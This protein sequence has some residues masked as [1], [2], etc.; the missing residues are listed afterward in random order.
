M[1]RDPP[2]VGLSEVEARLPITAASVGQWVH[3]PAPQS[4]SSRV[5]PQAF[6]E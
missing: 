5:F 1:Q 2:T 6:P 4:S 3:G